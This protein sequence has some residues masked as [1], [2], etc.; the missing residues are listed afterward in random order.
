MNE[1]QGSGGKPTFP[2]CEILQSR[3]RFRIE[4]LSIRSPQL[5][6]IKLEVGKVGWPPLPA[7]DLAGASEREAASC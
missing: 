7:N 3:G 6:L 2:T 4:S 1:D 5:N